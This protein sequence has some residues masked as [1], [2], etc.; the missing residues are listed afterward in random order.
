[1]ERG[2]RNREIKDEGE[3]SFQACLVEVILSFISTGDPVC[4]SQTVA[5]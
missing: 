3:N 2:G 5:G 4:V 1:M